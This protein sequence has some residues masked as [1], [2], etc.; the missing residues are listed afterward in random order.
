MWEIYRN[1]HS[2]C[3]SMPTTWRTV[4]LLIYRSKMSLA[5]NWLCMYTSMIVGWGIDF[6]PLVYKL[7]SL[8]AF[9]WRWE[10]QE[11][12]C[13]LL[14]YIKN[15]S[16]I[17]AEQYAWVHSQECMWMCMEEEKNWAR[18]ICIRRRNGERDMDWDCRAERRRHAKD[19]ICHHEMAAHPLMMP[20]V[21]IIVI[22]FLKSI[23]L[24][25]IHK[26]IQVYNI[27]VC[28]Q[29][30]LYEPMVHIKTVCIYTYTYIGPIYN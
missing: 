8:T 2:M 22:R 12:I 11:T 23:Q 15:I 19:V 29:C 26:Y 4:V 1:C 6:I 9:V 13:I 3:L 17:C 20:L 18:R 24:R 14:H 7:V 25:V 27:H 21:S 5:S 30:T 10:I 28:T 16:Y